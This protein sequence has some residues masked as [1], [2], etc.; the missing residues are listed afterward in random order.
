MITTSVLYFG[1]KVDPNKKKDQN[2]NF[3]IVMRC[4]IIQ[5]LGIVVAIVER[6]QELP[7]LHTLTP[8]VAVVT[9]AFAETV[10]SEVAKGK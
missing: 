5:V 2:I 8:V 7:N 6:I 1:I 4:S 9:N 3:P 10:E